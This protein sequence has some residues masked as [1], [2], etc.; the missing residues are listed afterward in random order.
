[1]DALLGCVSLLL[2]HKGI[3]MQSILLTEF[4]NPALIKRHMEHLFTCVWVWGRVVHALH[5]R[6]RDKLTLRS[7]A[8][9]LDRE[10]VDHLRL[11]QTHR[12]GAFCWCSI[13]I[14]IRL[15]KMT[16]LIR[17][18]IHANLGIVLHTA[19]HLR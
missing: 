7:F 15:F 8:I 3:Q 17:C 13:V 10:A 14:S 1:M 11:D 16:A 5:R 18:A 4:G 2:F 9:I 19:E 12:F 6:H